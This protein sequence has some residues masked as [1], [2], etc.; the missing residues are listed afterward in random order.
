MYR[1]WPTNCVGK[2]KEVAVPVIVGALETEASGSLL[3]TLQ[4][5]RHRPAQLRRRCSDQSFASDGEVPLRVR[6]DEDDPSLACPRLVELTICSCDAEDA[7]LGETVNSC[8]SISSSPT[9]TISTSLKARRMGTVLQPPDLTVH[10][11]GR[12]LTKCSVNDYN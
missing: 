3:V 11:T 4:T 6:N 12:H 5:T 2:W 7:R 8:V 9:P 10:S 1:P